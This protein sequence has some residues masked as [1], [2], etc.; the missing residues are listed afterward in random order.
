[1][2]DID[3]AWVSD[4][5]VFD[6]SKTSLV[7]AQLPKD[8]FGATS[9][10][11]DNQMMIFGGLSDNQVSN[12]DIFIF[13]INNYNVSTLSS[14]FESMSFGQKSYLLPKGDF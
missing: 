11:V 14:V 10:V 1:V 4:P 13:N 6:N 12:P 9:I 5:G 8:L 3:T 2:I 7:V